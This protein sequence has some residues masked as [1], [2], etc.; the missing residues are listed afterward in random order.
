MN[1][2]G[3][4]WFGVALVVIVAG[5]GAW[6]YFLQPTQALNVGVQLGASPSQVFVGDPF[7]LS[8][9]LSNNSASVMQSTTVSIVLPDGIVSLDAPNQRVVTQSLSNPV[10]PSAV[11]HQDFQLV[12]VGGA[13]T[14]VHATAKVVYSVAGSS[15]QFES[16]A[17]VDVPIGQPAVTASISVPGNVFSGQNFPVTVS[18]S[19]NTSHAIS[20]F[21]LAM[22]YPPAFTLVSGSST[23]SLGTIPAGGSATIKA[24]GNL[25]GPN[26]ASY[27]INATIVENVGGQNKTVASQ[28]ANVTLSESPLTFAI[29]V[30]NAQSYVSHTGDSLNYVLTFTNNSTVAF[31]NIVIT[32]KLAGAMF[33]FTSLSSNGAFSS[34]NNTITWNGAASSQLLSL[35]PGQSGSVNFFVRTKT[36]FPIRQLSDKN[37]SLSVNAKLQSPTVPG[38]TDASATISVANLSTK[39]AGAISLASKAYH[40]EPSGSGITNTGPYPPKVNK[41]TQYT[42]H[43]L[44]TNYATDADNVIIS[45]YLQS[46]TTC[47]GKMALPASTTLTCDPSSGQVTWKVPVIPAATGIADRPLEA[48][49]QL[50]NTPAVNQVGQ[51]ITLLGP[52]ALNATDAFTSSTLSSSAQPVTTDLPDDA[53]VPPNNRGVTQ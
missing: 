12:A 38:G 23:I 46:G 41:A 44:V 1:N 42:V 45:A 8:V 17:S 34:V 50:T 13:N 37:Y 49:F 35:A 52:V 25:V 11:S 19:N 39:L 15:A 40:R 4:I 18:Y 26:G 6:I 16:D 3:P 10:D 32:A 28:S 43:W 7:K 21:S 2:R 22:Q 24:S 9:T 47:T 27:P 30:N 5:V 51:S 33:D 31:Q 48:V 14:V 36:A 53:S 20:G 29:A